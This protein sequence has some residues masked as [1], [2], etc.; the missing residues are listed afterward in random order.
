VPASLRWIEVDY[1]DVIAFKQERLAGESPRCQLERIGQDLAAVDQRRE[2]LAQIDARAGRALILTEGVVPYLDVAQVAALADDLHR[3]AHVDAW[4]VDYISPESHAWRQ[5]SGVDRQMGEAA[6]KF[7]PPDWF[8][9]FA[10]HGW[11]S[12]EV[13]YLPEVG[14]QLGR[15]APLPRILRGVMK[16]LRALAPAGRRGRFDQFAGYVLLEPVRR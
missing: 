11:R 1:P 12:R 5:R 3:L 8:A 16:V 14:R 4:I 2:L 7:Q 6:F 9:F 15:P 10:E 13:R